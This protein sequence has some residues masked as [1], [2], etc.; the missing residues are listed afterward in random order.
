MTLKNTDMILY[1]SEQTKDDT[2]RYFP[3]AAKIPSCNAYIISNPLTRYVPPKDE[4]YFLYVGNMEKRKGVDI[5]IKAYRKYRENGGTRPL[6]LAGKMQE[7]DIEQLLENALTE[8]EGLTYLGYVSH[9]TRYDLYNNCSCFVFPSMAEGFG[10]PILEVM[11]HNKPILASNLRIFDEVV[12]DCV[13]RFSLAGDDEDKV[14]SLA[15]GMKNID[16]KINSGLVDENAYKNA[17]NKYTP[18]RLGGMVRDFI[19]SQMYNR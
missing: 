11:K 13:E 5:L 4:N 12:G 7:D 8:V 18:E 14:I 15:N 3:K 17:L 1:N 19:N 16:E 2:E 6:I 10:M 9:T